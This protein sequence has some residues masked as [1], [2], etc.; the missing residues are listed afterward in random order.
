MD[1]C[2]HTLK[3][4]IEQKDDRSDSYEPVRKVSD[5]QR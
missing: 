4:N 2:I 1:L 3:F 5:F